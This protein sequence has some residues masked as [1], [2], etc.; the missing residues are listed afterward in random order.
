MS[1]YGYGRGSLS[2]AAEEALAGWCR[3]HDEQGRQSISKVDGQLNDVTRAGVNPDERQQK[4]ETP[5][6][7]IDGESS[8]NKTTVGT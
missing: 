6:V 1:V 7:S 5:A 3:E 2:K 4:S 8:P